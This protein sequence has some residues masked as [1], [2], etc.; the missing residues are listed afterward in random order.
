MPK[1][2]TFEYIKEF[3]NKEELLISTEYMNNKQLLKIKCKKCK[4]IYNQTYDRYYRGYRHQKC[5]NILNS[6]TTCVKRWDNKPLLKDTT[7]NCKWCKKEYIPKKSKQKLCSKNCYVLFM[8][9][10]IEYLKNQKINGS[11]GGRKS[12]KSQ[13]LRGKA[14]IYFSELC[15]TYFGKHDI[16]CNERIFKD[17]NGNLWDCDI[18]IKSL[19]IAI[20]YDGIITKKYIK[21]RN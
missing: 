3:I 4:E 18:F 8:K 6:K 10:D 11:N 19:K 20:L 7:R 14:E 5:A 21:I 2:L 9:T 15:I 12:A 13:Q 1:K 17:S 16:I